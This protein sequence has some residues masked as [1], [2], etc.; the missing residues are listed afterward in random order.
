[1][2]TRVKLA[3]VRR[4]NPANGNG[5]QLESTLRQLRIHM[6]NLRPMECDQA[7]KLA[8]ST[9]DPKRYNRQRP[10]QFI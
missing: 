10:D 5:V 1:M 9:P 2:G 8:E 6:R 3:S 7:A 4:V